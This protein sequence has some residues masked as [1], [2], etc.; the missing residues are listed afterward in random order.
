MADEQICPQCGTSFTPRCHSPVTFCGYKCSALARGKKHR[1][2]PIP[3]KTCE[4]CGGAFT[5]DTRQGLDKWINRRFC[6]RKC[7]G[8]GRVKTQR[9]CAFCGLPFFP[10]DRGR[11]LAAKYCRDECYFLS[12]RTERY[13]VDR[14]PRRELEFTHRQK[15][16]LLEKAFGR[17]ARCGTTENPEVDHIIP[18]WNHGTNDL[19]NGQILCRPHHREKTSADVAAYWAMLAPLNRSV[20]KPIS[21]RSSPG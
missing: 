9:T 13:P 11:S 1:G 7:R 21:N 16:I 15:T 20:R 6:S 5:Q 14:R 17:C 4:R 8:S 2:G 12:L 18:I 19:A 10:A 3:V